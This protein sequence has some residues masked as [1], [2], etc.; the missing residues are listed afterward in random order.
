MWRAS[1]TPSLHRF[2][3]KARQTPKADIDVAKQ[4][5]RQVIESIRAEEQP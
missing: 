5:Y 3:K 2:E 1:A 4:R